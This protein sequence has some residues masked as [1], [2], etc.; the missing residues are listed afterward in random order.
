MMVFFRVR[1]VPRYRSLRGIFC[2]LNVRHSGGRAQEE[3]HKRDWKLRRVEAEKGRNG[4]ETIAVGAVSVNVTRPSIF[5]CVCV[6]F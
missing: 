2:N 3:V 6:L 4:R 5:A 1:Y